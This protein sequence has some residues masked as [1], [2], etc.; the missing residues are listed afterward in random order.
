MT[1]KVIK[2]WLIVANPLPIGDLHEARLSSFI[3]A[4]C[5]ATLPTAFAGAQDGVQIA[6]AHAQAQLSSHQ[7]QPQQFH[8]YQPR[9]YADRRPIHLLS[10]N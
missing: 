4:A 6:R 10:L 9:I 8:A 2:V 7:I 3:A 1:R 5:L